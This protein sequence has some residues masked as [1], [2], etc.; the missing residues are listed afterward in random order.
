M[1]LQ[2]AAL[3]SGAGQEARLGIQ[4]QSVHFPLQNVGIVRDGGEVERRCVLAPR[5][6]NR[7]V[8]TALLSF[9]QRLTFHQKSPSVNHF[10]HFHRLNPFFF[11]FFF[12]LCVF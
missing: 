2:G 8:E 9:A 4:R 7:L 1:Y 6:V 11:F 5:A 3:H 10:Q 12:F